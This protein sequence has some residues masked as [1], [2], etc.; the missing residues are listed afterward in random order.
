MIMIGRLD[1]YL[2]E[3]SADN[4]RLCEQELRWAGLSVTSAHRRLPGA[5]V[6]GDAD[7]RRAARQR[8]T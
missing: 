1:D 3:V 8:T 4:G 6:R 2:R 7:G 5:R